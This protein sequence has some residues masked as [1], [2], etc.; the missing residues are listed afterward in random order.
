[1]KNYFKCGEEKPLRDYYVH[2]KMADGH[3]NKCKTCV[4]EYAR[5]RRVE[6]PEIISAIDQKRGQRPDRKRLAKGYLKSTRARH[7]EKYHARMAI[8]NAVRGGRISRMPCEVCGDP[9]SEGHHD[10]YSKPLEV[11]W[12]CFKHHREVVHGQHVVSV[13][14]DHDA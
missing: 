9:K 2:P 14:P 12:L 11:R 1:M 4:I 5:R 6:S 8:A 3:L 13:L 7:P 10:D